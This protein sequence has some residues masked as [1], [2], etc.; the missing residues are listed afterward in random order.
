MAKQEGLPEVRS[1]RFA[2]PSEDAPILAETADLVRLSK[3]IIIKTDKGEQQVN[4][5]LLDVKTTLKYAV[6][7]KKDLL[8]PVKEQILNP[9]DSYYKKIIPPL[10]E[11]ER[12]FKSA[13]G[14]YQMQK[15]DELRELTAI[16]KDNDAGKGAMVTFEEETKVEGE[17]GKSIVSYKWVGVVTSVDNIPVEY[18]RS[19]VRT[20]RG[21]EGLD[22]VIRGLVDGGIRAIP[23]VEIKEV[24]QIAVTVR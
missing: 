8:A 7:E 15:R 18:L 14:Q 22:E 19:A 11:A 1:F 9:I 2:L 21:A 6:E 10:Q 4:T 24:P 5:R 23:G 16:L 3:K 20:K 17:N 12:V 13:I